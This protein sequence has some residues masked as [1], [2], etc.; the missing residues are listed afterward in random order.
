MRS[1]CKAYNTLKLVFCKPDSLKQ[2]RTVTEKQ[3]QP[4]SVIY[5]IKMD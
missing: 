2:K 5:A 3:P 1:S 4:S